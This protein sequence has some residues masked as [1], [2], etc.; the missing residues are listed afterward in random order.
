MSIGE[1]MLDKWAEAI[2]RFEGWSTTSLSFRNNNPGNIRPSPQPWQGQV[3]I[4]SHNFVVFDSYENG[5]RALKISLQN[6]ANGHS[7]VY[8]SSDTLYDFFGRY[9][10]SSDNNEPRKYAEYV[11]AQLGVE[12]TTQI[13][14]LV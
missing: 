3:G 8:K 9:A 6:A 13:S 7:S 14:Q 11:A 2:K 10:P 1:S 12:P 5:M 4:D